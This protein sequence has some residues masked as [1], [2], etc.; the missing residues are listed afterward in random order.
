MTQ[1]K[2]KKKGDPPLLLNEIYWIIKTHISCRREINWSNSLFNTYCYS[3]FYS[4]VSYL[5]LHSSNF[6]LI[7]GLNTVI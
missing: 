1:L 6:A 5:H 7:L 4:D 2:E 3:Y